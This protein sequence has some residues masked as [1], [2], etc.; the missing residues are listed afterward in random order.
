MNANRILC[1][2][3]AVALAIALTACAKGGGAM[4]NGYY[5]AISSE[6]DEYGW[7]EYV[8]IYVSN[9]KIVTVE[10][11]ARDASG[12]IKS[13]DM[14]YMRTMNGIDGTY[15]NYYT[16]SYKTSLLNRQRTE[17][18]DAVTGATVSHRTFQALV[19]AAMEHARAG[20]RNIAKVDLTSIY[21]QETPS[22]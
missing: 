2:L 8:T 7:K 10:Y 14:T 16:R 12:Y 4:H 1:V 5:T 22:E 20:D 9:D 6:F 15:P 13:W 18:V 21:S 3:T 11:D 19:E 17:G